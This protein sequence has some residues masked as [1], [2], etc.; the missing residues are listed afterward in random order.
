MAAESTTGTLDEV[1][2]AVDWAATPVGDPRTWSPAMRGAL[3]LV[4]GTHLPATL[5]WGPEL[6]LLYN[7]AYIPL[8]ADK[9]PAALGARARDVFP[10]AWET[11]GPLLHSVLAGE[12]TVKLDE[13][14]VPLHRRG[15]L[16]ECFFTFSYSAVCSAPEPAEPEV[17]AEQSLQGG[18]AEL[19]WR[20]EG[21]AGPDSAD[22]ERV[23]EGVIDIAVETTAQVQDRRR[24]ALLSRVNEALAEA[25]YLTD[26]VHQALE[27]LRAASSDLGEVD[28]HQPAS[29][30]PVPSGSISGVRLPARPSRPARSWLDS[31]VVLEKTTAGTLAWLPL[32]TG[33]S[34]APPAMLVV[35]LHPMLAV[36]ERHLQFLQLLAA[37]LAQ[38]F[39]RVQVREERRRA[40]AAG[41]AMSEA[42]QRSLLDQPA[43]P[44][45]FEVAV[46]YQPAA[47]QAQVGGDWYDAFDQR[48][49]VLAVVVG[50]VSGHDREAAVTMAQVRNL[51]RGV[52]LSTGQRPAAVLGGLEAAM[53]ALGLEAYATAVLAQVEVAGGAGAPDAS[54]AASPVAA[55]SAAH[56]AWPGGSS[57]GGEEV[58]VRWANAGHPPP[59]L[60]SED[61]T[62]VLLEP[63]TDVLLGLSVQ[64]ERS[65][66][67]VVLPVGA[68]LVLYT[69]GLVERRGTSLQGAL[70]E[71]RDFLRGCHRLSAEQVCDQLLG[72]FSA[73]A[74]DDIVVLVLRRL[75]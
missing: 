66:H 38:A 63:E 20:G 25:A 51:L 62:A 41:R 61:G 69:D 8:I 22:R 33:E 26:A 71:L 9:H 4:R 72:R 18:A 35:R 50:D 54:P 70:G 53:Q 74:D 48:E 44:D 10:E 34:S 28:I 52:A 14:P 2:D 68:Y 37:A 31:D 60:V 13:A 30:T 47:D 73:G 6:V 59:V 42:L 16:E 19:A 64:R 12:G 29:G 49:G 32:G 15:F 75:G 57:A 5:L 27:V 36:D 43:H 65:D 1:Y 55:P 40:A 21:A 39:S 45:R 56:A 24:L 23:V 7:E 11:I 17:P 3:D 58:V 67:V 46:R